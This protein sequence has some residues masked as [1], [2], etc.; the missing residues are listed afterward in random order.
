MLT[1][2]QLAELKEQLDRLP[3][4]QF[5]SPVSEQHSLFTY[6]IEQPIAH[7]IHIQYM[8]F[9]RMFDPVLVKE[10]VRYITNLKKK[11][12]YKRRKQHVDLS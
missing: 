8:E 7:G 10:M 6:G 9:F 1:Y 3:D 11:H 5:F 2:K 12:T 4:T